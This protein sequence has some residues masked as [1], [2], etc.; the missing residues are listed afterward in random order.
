MLGGSV[1]T[2]QKNTD[3]LL[4][5]RKRTELEVYAAKTN[6]VFMSRNQNTGRSQN[7]KIDNSSFER[8]E[9]FKY[10]ETTLTIKILFRRKLRAS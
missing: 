6:Y 9:H 4:V 7:M 2:I 3:S 1:H 5:S 10:L 8:M